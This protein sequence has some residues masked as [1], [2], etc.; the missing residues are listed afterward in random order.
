M[1]V[2][3]DNQSTQRETCTSATLSTTHLSWTEQGLN[4]ALHGEGPVTKGLSHGRALLVSAAV[5]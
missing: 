3:M 2:T 1:I 4:L 5:I